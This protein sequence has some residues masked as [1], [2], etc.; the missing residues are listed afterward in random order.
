MDKKSRRVDI[1][2]I[3]ANPITKRNMMI[4]LIVAAAAME[5]I[6]TTPEQATQAYD[7]IQEEKRHRVV[8]GIEGIETDDILRLTS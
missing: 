1:K 5:G 4:N 8:N 3:L 6:D 2:A 7:K